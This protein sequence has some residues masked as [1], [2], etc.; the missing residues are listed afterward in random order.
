MITTRQI[1]LTG[2]WHKRQGM[3]CQDI[4][5]IKQDQDHATLVLCDG[6]GGCKKGGEAA[7]IVS[8]IILDMLHINFERYL[9]F[10]YDIVKREILLVIREHLQKKAIISGINEQEYGT[11]IVAASLDKYGHFVALHMGDGRIIMEIDNGIYTPVS[12]PQGINNGKAT[13]L[14][15]SCNMMKHFRLYQARKTTT[16]RIILL[17]DGVETLLNELSFD[18]ISKE[19]KLNDNMDELL[20]QKLQQNEEKLFDDA[21][22]GAIGM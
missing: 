9:Y 3:K 1:V 13:Y 11:T 6:A 21:S 5:R 8:S 20:I 12:S 10:P 2:I 18:D 4:V 15:M 17:S 22:I 7:E 16:R 14:T 19:W